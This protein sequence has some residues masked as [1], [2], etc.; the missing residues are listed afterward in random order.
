MNKILVVDDQKAVCYSLQRFLGS[1]GYNVVTAASGEEALKIVNNEIPALVIMDVRMPEMDGIEVLGEIKKSHPKIQVIMMTA[2]ST[3][4]KAIHAMKLG[5][6]DY[7]IKPFDN[8][9]LLI[10]IKDAIKTRELMKEVVAFDDAED[11]AGSEKIVGKSPAMLAIYKQIGKAA[12]TNAAVLI[13]GESGTGKELI[14][15]AL[16][17]QQPFN[18]SVPCH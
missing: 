17:L 1:E 15:R 18:K 13:K 11:Y 6:Y 14:A 12:P 8:D 9:E 3:T 4:E 2:F 16:S 7:I 5:A 10:R